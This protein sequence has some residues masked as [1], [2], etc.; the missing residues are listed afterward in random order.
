MRLRG[1]G[2]HDGG[3][4]IRGTARP[5]GSRRGKPVNVADVLRHTAVLMLL[6]A[7]VIH[8][9]VTPEHFEEWV[10]AG[11]FFVVIT[12]VQAGL[13]LGLLLSRRRVLY[14]P[15]LVVSAAAVLVWVVSRTTGLPFGPDAGTPEEVG[16]PDTVATIFEVATV[17]VTLPLL[18]LGPP[19]ATGRASRWRWAVVAVIA[20]VVIAMTGFAIASP[21]EP[22]GGHAAS[23]TGPLVPVETL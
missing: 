7:A 19:I 14:F 13:A 9:K 12:V 2:V 17:A 21:E 18:T 8:A 20:V 23:P 4:T 22:R 1:T 15:A 5:A 16:R 3:M 10:A 11:V 6:G